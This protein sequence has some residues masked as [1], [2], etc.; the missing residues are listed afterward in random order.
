VIQLRSILVFAGLA[1][2]GCDTPQDAPRMHDEAL[3][4]VRD[5]DARLDDLKR[6]ADDLDHRRGALPHDT[7]SSAATEHT[8]GQARSV[9]EDDRGYLKT[10]RT[11]LQK[12][13]TV[14]ELQVLLDELRRRLDDGLTEATSEIGAVESAVWIAEQRAPGA[15]PPAP[16]PPEP[17]TEDRAPETD[18]SGAP[19][20]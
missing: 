4:A 16:P 14:G 8:L 11:K 18:R 13:G 17:P 2:A 7:L 12:P 3:A 19:I 5:Y 20:R 10:V 15:Q 6:R 1:A 9:I